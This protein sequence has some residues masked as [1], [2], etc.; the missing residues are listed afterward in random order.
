MLGTR[1]IVRVL[2]TGV[3]IRSIALLCIVNTW[4][5]HEVTLDLKVPILVI[6]KTELSCVS[7]RAYD[8]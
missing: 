3:R 1:D 2:Q 7:V 5:D 8:K 4:V 6:M